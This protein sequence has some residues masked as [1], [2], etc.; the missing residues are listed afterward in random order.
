M[1][2]TTKGDGLHEKKKTPYGFRSTQVCARIFNHGRG[3]SA[4]AGQETALGLCITTA[5]ATAT[6]TATLV[7]FEPGPHTPKVVIH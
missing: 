3:P 4:K 7:P 2:A 6:A 1:K 5:T